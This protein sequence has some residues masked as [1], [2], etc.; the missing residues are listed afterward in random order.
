MWIGPGEAFPSNTK[1]IQVQNHREFIDIYYIYIHLQWF[2]IVTG[3]LE[4]L[5]HPLLRFWLANS[6]ISSHRAMRSMDSSASW[7]QVSL[8][9]YFSFQ[10]TC[11]PTDIVFGVTL[12]WSKFIS[13]NLPGHLLLLRSFLGSIFLFFISFVFE[14]P[15]FHV[16]PVFLRVSTS[17]RWVCLKIGYIP[18]Y[19][20][21]IGIM[22]IHHWV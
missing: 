2:S 5:W 9:P 21:L 1:Y 19:S 6:S 4:D 3:L 16:F 14:E 22:I 18:N 15:V 13:L 8:P 12:T 20:H 11:C 7:R 10:R 17:P